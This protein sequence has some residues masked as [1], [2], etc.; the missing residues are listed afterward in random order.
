METI[1]IFPSD[2]DSLPQALGVIEDLLALIGQL[3]ERIE[4]LEAENKRLRDQLHLDSH[5]SSFPPSSDKGHDQKSTKSLRRKSSRKP[6]AQKGHEGSTLKQVETPDKV[7]FHPVSVCTRCGQD[8]SDAPVTAV[9]KR[10]VFELPPLKLEVT[11][12]QVELKTCPRCAQESKGEFPAEVR[13]PVQYGPRVKGLLVYLNQE[14]LIPY[15]RTTLLFED[16]LGQPV[17]QGTLLRANHTC[18]AHLVSTE[19]AIKHEIQ[20]SDVA[21]FDETGLYEKGKR[22]WLHS[23]STPGL[24]YYFAHEKRGKDAMQA[25]DV[26][27]H[28]Q[29]TAVHDHWESY[30]TFTHCGHAFCN[31]HHVRELN[32]AIEQDDAQW[33]QEM[34]TLLL[35]IKETVDTAKAEGETELP[36]EQIKDFNSLYRDIVDRA[37]MPYLNEPSSNTP[38]KRGRT[39]QSKTKNLLDR[40]DKYQ[41]ETL[42]FMR[43]FRV[44]FDNNL[45][46]RDIRMTKVKQK[47]SG[48]FRSSNGTQY[49][50][51]IRGF[52]STLKKQRRNILESLTQTFN[53]NNTGMAV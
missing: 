27:P 44:P 23:A 3:Q 46:E 21:N 43:D 52:I 11:E 18:Y 15:E 9:E 25:A 47:I 38:P 35:S 29:G 49:F 24:T 32:R 30:E 22:I 36:S 5:N 20:Q 45:A 51:R 37:L 8:L 42:R 1:S 34:K 14:Q 2:I 4:A 48:T 53:T 6:G 17:S 31:A 10:Q 33:A 13:Q 7:V 26:L 40:F 28:F 39:K 16:L 41:P 19:A 12:H 50:C